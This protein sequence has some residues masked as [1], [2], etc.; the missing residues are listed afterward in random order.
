MFGK[1]SH[2]FVQRV[3]TLVGRSKCRLTRTIPRA[4]STLGLALSCVVLAACD[5]STPIEPVAEPITSPPNR[6]AFSYSTGT[7]QVVESSVSHTKVGY[8]EYVSF[9]DVDGNRYY[10]EALYDDFGRLQVFKAYVNGEFVGEDHPSWS[11]MQR[12]G[13]S[14][15]NFSYWAT[16]TPDQQLTNWG[17]A[18]DSNG[19]AGEG[20]DGGGGGG[21]TPETCDNMLASSQDNY[22]YDSCRQ[23]FA[24][25]GWESVG[26]WSTY[27]ALGGAVLTAEGSGPAAPWL[28]GS[29]LG[30]MGYQARNW[31]RAMRELDTCVRMRTV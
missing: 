5:R 9:A 6:P 27:V 7:V 17:I 15:G 22:L 4:R 24:N 31:Y 26:L 3:P 25:F 10:M 8:N 23:Q 20:G 11:G 28:I 13:H 21:C 19:G 2:W 18:G 14:S 1:P 16:S 29:A 12:T 30:A